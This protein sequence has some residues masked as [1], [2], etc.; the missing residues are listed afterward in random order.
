M[1]KKHNK[2]Y[3]VLIIGAGA[4]GLSLAILL[5]QAGLRVACFD[6]ADLSLSKSQ[7][8]D[9]RTTAL[10]Y[11]TSVILERAGVWKD[12]VAKACGIEDIE[13][14]QDGA[15]SYL[16][17]LKKDIDAPAFG[18]VVENTHMRNVFLSHAKKIKSLNL[19]GNVIC[20]SFEFKESSAIIK[21]KNGQ[22]FSAPLLIGADGRGSAVRE[23][24]GIGTRGHEYHQSAVLCSF[25]HSLPHDNK[26]LEDFRS[27]GPLAVLPMAGETKNTHRSALVWTQ[28]SHSRPALE[29]L[30]DNVF[31]AGLQARLPERYGNVL[32]VSPR[33]IYPLNLI[34]AQRYIRARAALIADA[35]HGIHPIAG[36]GLNLGLRDVDCLSDLIIEAHKAGQDLGSETLLDSYERTRQKDNMVM[37]GATDTLNSIFSNPSRALKPFRAAGLKLIGRMPKTKKFLMRYAMGTGGIVSKN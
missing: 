13:I 21:L 6:R 18:W 8:P 20:E 3:D 23:A 31:K 30:S 22:I 36:Q 2:D 24:L 28:E 10:S 33:R 16:D 29:S 5:G 35:A 4:A 32:D 15:P 14:T 34:H 9:R 17:F 1:I 26:A 7:A 25:T 12:I 11:G 37:A 19:Y 27:A